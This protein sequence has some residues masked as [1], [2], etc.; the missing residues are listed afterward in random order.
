MP[1]YTPTSTFF[2]NGVVSVASTDTTPFTSIIQSMG[3]F[4]YGVSEIYINSNSISQI[5]QPYRF[6]K[7]NADGTITSFVDIPTIDPYQ[8]QPS[9]NRKLA[10]DDVVLDGRT[11]FD[12]PILPSEFLNLVLYTK[13]TSVSSLLPPTNFFNNDFFNLFNDYKDEI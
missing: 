6:N 10:E 5:L 11:A 2:A 3:S 8:F 1:T 4:T 12:F 9:V 7:K 13:Q